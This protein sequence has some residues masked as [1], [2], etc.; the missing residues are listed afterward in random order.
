MP[1]DNGATKVEPHLEPIIEPPQS[2]IALEQ[3]IIKGRAQ[4][5]KSKTKGGKPPFR[6]TTCTQHSQA[7]KISLGQCPCRSSF[8]L[9]LAMNYTQ[10]ASKCRS[11]TPTQAF[12]QECQASHLSTD[13]VRASVSRGEGHR[14]RARSDES[15]ITVFL[16]LRARGQRGE[17]TFKDVSQCPLAVG[18][19]P[20]LPQV[21]SGVA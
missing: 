6:D 15:P 10:R 20:L 19:R 17:E 11:H 2:G 18:G 4:C 5:T 7:F 13:P 14:Q 21:I 1:D 3:L 12:T 9:L 16:A 8:N